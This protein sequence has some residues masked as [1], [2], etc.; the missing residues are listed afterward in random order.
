V[1][2]LRKPVTA[3][4]GLVLAIA[5]GLTLAGCGRKG[6]LE[7]PPSAALPQPVQG[8][9]SVVEP[10]PDPSLASVLPEAAPAPP[11]SPSLAAPPR[12]NST[13]LDWLLN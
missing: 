9:Q 4:L 3:G 12:Q 10:P 1:A 6:G 2:G 8:Q 7:A 13:P 11:P 5:A